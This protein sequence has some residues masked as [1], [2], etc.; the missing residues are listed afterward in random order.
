[1]TK[2][3]QNEHQENLVKAYYKAFNEKNFNS[4]INLLTEDIVHEVNQGKIVVGR[5]RFLSFL[6]H[7]DTCY[8]EEICDL[9]ILTSKHAQ[10]AAAEFMVRGIYL[11]KD[12]EFPDAHRQ[13]YWLKVGA[14][15]HFD[16]DKINQVTTYY[17]VQN[18]KKQ[19][20]QLPHDIVIRRL[21]SKDLLARIN[22]LARLRIA[23]FREFPYLYDGSYEYEK[24]YLH[25]YTQSPG[26]TVIAALKGNELIGAA[27]AI[28]LAYE[29][30]YVKEPFLAAGIDL[31]KVF[32]FGESILL[33]E[34]RGIG[35]GHKFFDGRELAALEMKSIEYTAFC[36]VIRTDNHPQKPAGY[37]SLEDFWRSRGYVKTAHLQSQFSW[38]EISEDSESSKPMQYWMRRWAR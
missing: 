38:K 18:W 21:E 17:N 28:P 36:A 25:V 3:S 19:I 11:Q 14:F 9:R 35:I 26:A 32:Y 12:G 4:M 7:M 5:A 13:N 15:F 29:N 37:R 27:T 2:N 24:K 16:D 1:M 31:C 34:F 22:D 30:D 33:K 10:I 8:D 23:V 20:K 6:K